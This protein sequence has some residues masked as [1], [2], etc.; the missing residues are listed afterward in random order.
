MCKYSSVYYS[1]YRVYRPVNYSLML[2]L[3]AKVHCMNG[4]PC[5][6]YGMLLKMVKKAPGVQATI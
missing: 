3:L 4:C 2:K 5:K 6:G 1:I